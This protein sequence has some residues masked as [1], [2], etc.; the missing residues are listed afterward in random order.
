MSEIQ[1][2]VF[3]L[4]KLLCVMRTNAN[5]ER[6]I[7]LT[8][9][10]SFY[11]ADQ[12]CSFTK[13]M[14]FWNFEDSGKVCLVTCTLKALTPDLKDGTTY[15]L[16]KL[17]I[18]FSNT[19]F[20]FTMRKPC[21]HVRNTDVE[22]TMTCDE[23]GFYERRIG[24]SCTN[25]SQCNVSNP[26]STCNPTNGVC[27]CKEGYFEI[28]NTCFQEKRIGES[29][30]EN[31][32]CDVS[33]PNSTCNTS[34]GVWEC[35]EGYF[36]MFNTCFQEHLSMGETCELNEQCMGNREVGFCRQTEGGKVCSPFPETDDVHSSQHGG[37]QTNSMPNSTKHSSADSFETTL[38]YASKEMARNNDLPVG[39]IAG[40]AAAGFVLGIIFCGIFCVMLSRCKKSTSEKRS[41]E[42][43]ATVDNYGFNVVAISTGK[44]EQKTVQVSEERSRKHVDRKGQTSPPDD[45]YNHLNEA[46]GMSDIQPEYD[47]VPSNDTNGE[48]Y[49]RLDLNITR[50]ANT[51]PL[52]DMENHYD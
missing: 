13:Q 34:N 2:L 38:T 41:V 3:F 19:F 37:F 8:D 35:K 51:T 42:F 23:R 9:L 20:T 27:E 22:I 26:Y 48:T 4:L 6:T 50:N 21:G 11:D 30:T 33:N 24:E 45:I 10:L 1:R 28:F 5:T 18:K 49:H 46:S 29:C 36:E 15:E 43:A 32:L 52:V 40:A 25:Q 39:M 31:S 17:E 16:E 14:F 44:T 12:S 7:C 47:H